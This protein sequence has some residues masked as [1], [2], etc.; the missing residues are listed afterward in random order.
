M[1]NLTASL[2]TARNELNA[3]TSQGLIQVVV[4][5]LLRYHLSN[6][7]FLLSLMFFYTYAFLA[8]LYE[9]YRV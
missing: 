8:G 2:E 3:S 6:L 7:Y 9:A 4:S 1:K 5:F